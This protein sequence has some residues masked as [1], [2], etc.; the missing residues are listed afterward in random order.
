MYCLR[1]SGDNIKQ[2][3]PPIHQHFEPVYIEIGRTGELIYYIVL[4]H[5]FFRPLLTADI[6]SFDRLQL[7][8]NFYN[9]TQ[10]PK[11][12]TLFTYRMDDPNKW[13][14]ESKSIASSQRGSIKPSRNIHVNHP[15]PVWTKSYSPL[16]FIVEI[17]Q[18]DSQHHPP[19]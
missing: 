10:F 9:T 15:L 4:V 8:F 19:N 2:A 11:V 1:S 14:Q 17:Y 5:S 6:D 13:S 12:H 16:T 18:C 7:V 3:H